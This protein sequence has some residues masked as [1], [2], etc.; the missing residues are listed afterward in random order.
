MNP[1]KALESSDKIMQGVPA[2][3]AIKNTPQGYGLVAVIL[4]WLA[5]LAVIALFPLGLWMTGLDYYDDWYR[6]APEIH[7][8]VGVLLFLTLL[9][10]VLWRVLNVRPED[11][12]G[13]GPLQRRLAHSAHFLLYLLLFALM[14]SGYLISTADG[15]AVEVF[16]L[17]SLPATI[18]GI[19]DQE[20]S[21][22]LVHWYLALALVGLVGLHALAALKHHFI[23]RDRTLKKML[24]VTACEPQSQPQS[25]KD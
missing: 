7:K 18:T 12:P 3:I 4:H 9:A 20:D 24:G 10:R 21:A 23:N 8:G 5:A 17:F 19:P 15:R 1:T 16:G 14:I 2:G 6:R 25:I 13:I 11:E 22:G